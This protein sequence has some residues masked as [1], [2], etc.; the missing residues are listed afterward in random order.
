MGVGPNEEAGLDGVRNR[1]GGAL[2]RRYGSWDTVLAVC[3]RSIVLNIGTDG[4]GIGSVTVNVRRGPALCARGRGGTGFVTIG[5][6]TVVGT[7]TA[8]SVRCSATEG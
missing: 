6:S 1:I 5:D 8:V 7:G 4:F 3:G 2:A